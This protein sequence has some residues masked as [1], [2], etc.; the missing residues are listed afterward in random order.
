MV[1][2]SLKLNPFTPRAARHAK[3]RSILKES[4]YIGSGEASGHACHAG[5]E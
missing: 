2:N 5:H 3:A 4:E 1:T